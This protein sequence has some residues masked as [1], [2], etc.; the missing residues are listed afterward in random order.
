MSLFA[1][2][3]LETNYRCYNTA[4]LVEEFCLHG[5]NIKYNATLPCVI[6]SNDSFVTVFSTFKN[7]KRMLL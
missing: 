2:E 1:S 7:T 4:Y 5:E 3:F 6:I